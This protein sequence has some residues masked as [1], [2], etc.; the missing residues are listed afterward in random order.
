[1]ERFRRFGRLSSFLG[2]GLLSMVLPAPQALAVHLG[3]TAEINPRLI[4]ASS[5]D[6]A[7]DLTVYNGPQ[8]GGPPTGLLP[9]NGVMVH[10]P[11]GY[12]PKS[13]SAPS[14]W[15]SEILDEQRIFF[16]QG[17]IGL[18]EAETFTIVLDVPSTSATQEW[19]VGASDDGG[20]TM[21]QCPAAFPGALDVTISS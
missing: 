8:T 2:L 16:H 21:R 10:I 14:P 17:E 13:A 9:A 18:G 5:L 1:M 15:E 3:C 7:L 19:G 12:Q 20:Y 6:Q 11:S 4:Q